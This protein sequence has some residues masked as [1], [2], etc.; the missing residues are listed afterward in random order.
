MWKI[1]SKVLFFS[2]F[3]LFFFIRSRLRFFVAIVSSIV[4]CL[5]FFGFCKISRLD[6]RECQVLIFQSI[7]TKNTQSRVVDQRGSSALWK[8]KKSRKKYRTM[9][10]AA[11]TT[12][13][14][15]VQI[16][17]SCGATWKRN[18]IGDEIAKSFSARDRRERGARREIKNSNLCNEMRRRREGER[19]LDEKLFWNKIFFTIDK[20]RRSLKVRFFSLSSR[21]LAEECEAFSSADRSSVLNSISCWLEF[22]DFFPRMTR[23]SDNN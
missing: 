22:F 5:L 12:E 15:K 21:K 4:L 14:I 13:S 1:N 16:V 20:F 9:V 17:L 2:Y 6:A 3:K 10:N 8:R 18:K 7:K 23:S 11:K 19:V